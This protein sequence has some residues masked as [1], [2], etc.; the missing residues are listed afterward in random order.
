MQ[1]ALQIKGSLFTF[2][3]IQIQSPDLGQI[4]NQLMMKVKQAPQFFSNTPVILDLNKIDALFDDTKLQ[5]LHT[6]LQKHTLV[7]LAY[8]T[9]NAT[10][11]AMLAKCSLPWLNQTAKKNHTSEANTADKGQTN[12]IES[13]IRSGQ[14]VSASADLVVLSEISPGAELT[15][16]NSIHVYGTLRGRAFAGLNGDINAR[17]FCHHLEA[18]LVAIAGHY[19]LFDNNI[20]VGPE[21]A[22]GYCIQLKNDTI[23]VNPL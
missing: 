18:D 21:F 11:Q 1:S 15:A 23:E 9:N 17:I 2:T 14:Q 5:R 12:V 20:P 6:M 22:K 16:H 8:Q 4:E 19:R 3:V 10:C 13:R 7:P